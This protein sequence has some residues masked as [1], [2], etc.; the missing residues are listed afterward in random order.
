M[1]NILLQALES[2]RANLFRASVTMVIIALGIGCLVGVL[3]AI[4]GIKHGFTTSFSSL[5]TNTFQIENRSRMMRM[6]GRGAANKRYPG[7]D[8][9]EAHTFREYFEGKALVAIT[10]SGNFAATLK[11]GKQK[12]NPNIQCIGADENYLQV[13]KYKVEDGRNISPEEARQGAKVILLGNAVKKA[14]FPFGSAVGEKINMDN[15]I[16][17]VIG[18]LAELGTSG[19]MGGDKIVLI[20]LQTLRSDFPNDNRSFTINVSVSRPQTLPL[21][22]EEARGKFRQIRKQLPREEDNF[23]LTKSDQFIKQLE[24]DLSILTMAATGIGFITLLGA[25]IALLNVMLVSVTDRTKEIGVRKAL[26]ATKG[27]IL[28]QFLWEAIL[29]CQLGGL[30]GILMGMFF[31]FAV[32][33]WIFKA[34]FLIPWNWIALGIVLCFIVGLASGIYPAWKAARVDPIESLRYE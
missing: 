11:A 10:G 34:S 27:N 22:M 32:S 4:D 3:A 12:T 5:G 18:V 7:I 33:V 29:I 9:H 21:V 25:S 8:Y 19:S 16:Y 2:V 1:F 28:S 15:H 6:G 31:G 17:Q 13:F 14:L 30:M 20:P 23:E 26:G 24:E